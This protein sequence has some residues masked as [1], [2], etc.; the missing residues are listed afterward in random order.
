MPLQAVCQDWVL[1]EA[2]D[3]PLLAMD[4]KQKVILLQGNYHRTWSLKRKMPVKGK[5]V[6]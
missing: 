3:A 6:N 5:K 1:E 4:W 2:G